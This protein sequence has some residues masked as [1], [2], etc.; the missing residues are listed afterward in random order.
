MQRSPWLGTESCR[1]FLVYYHLDLLYRTWP[2][3]PAGLR[4]PSQSLK[5]RGL[6][7][8]RHRCP[9]ASGTSWHDSPGTCRA[10]SE[11]ILYTV[12]VTAT[13]ALVLRPLLEDHTVNPYPGVCRQNKT[14]MFSD[15]NETS[16]S[17][18]AVSAPSVACSMHAVQ[19]RRRLCRQFVNVSAARRGC[20]TLIQLNSKC[21]W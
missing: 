11:A 15:H 7:P 17:I 10:L 20:H 8:R 12:T 3:Y 2:S 4:P 13:K 18:A 21:R 5:E 1:P 19:Q 6:S 14:E 9:Y 16:P